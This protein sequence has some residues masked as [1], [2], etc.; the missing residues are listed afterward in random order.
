L[1]HTYVEGYQFVE[2]KM[3]FFKMNEEENN[4]EDNEEKKRRNYWR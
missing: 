1:S 3:Q 2:N 4:E